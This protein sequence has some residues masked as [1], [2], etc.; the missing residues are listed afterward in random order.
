MSPDS[1]GQH[2]PSADPGFNHAAHD[3]AEHHLR[4]GWDVAV[5]NATDGQFL[6]YRASDKMWVPGD[7]ATAFS[8]YSEYTSFGPL[9]A[10][11]SADSSDDIGAPDST[12]WDTD[13]YF[14][15]GMDVQFSIRGMF[16]VHIRVV[17]SFAVF[18]TT[19]SLVLEP[20]GGPDTTFAATPFPTDFEG[21]AHAAGSSPTA[22]VLEINWHQDIPA[23]EGDGLDFNI[24]NHTDKDADPVLVWLELVRL[25]DIVPAFL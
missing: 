7:A 16:R 2:D 23:F 18:P 12:F 3:R 24:S 14:G 11:S 9:T 13:A 10:A 19:G 5:K 17:A 20:Y 21:I 8:G 6:K 22:K 4:S 25:G 15:N 1:S